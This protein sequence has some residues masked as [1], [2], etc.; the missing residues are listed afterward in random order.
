MRRTVWP[1]AIP[2]YNL[3]YDRFIEQIVAVEAA[4]PGLLIGGPVRD[5]IAV[6]QCLTAGEKLAARAQDGVTK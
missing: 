5:G 4:Y 3:G 6:P 2:Q 1:K